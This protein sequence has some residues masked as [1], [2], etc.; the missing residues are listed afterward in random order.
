VNARKAR[1]TA[2]VLA[3]VAAVF[4]ADSATAHTEMP[5][6]AVTRVSN[7]P[8]T[9]G[10]GGTLRISDRT[11]NRGG[12]SAGR[13]TTRYFIGRSATDEKATVLRGGRTVEPLAPRASHGSP[14]EV[15][16]PDVPAGTYEL[17]ACADARNRIRESDEGNNCGSA[18]RSMRVRANEPPAVFIGG[19]S[20]PGIPA[21]VEGEASPLMPGLTVTDPDDTR[22]TGAT[23][24][25]IGAGGAGL[26][27]VNQLGITGTYNS[28]TGVLTL[29][30]TANGADYR[31]A[32]R[33]V[34]YRFFGDDP[35]GSQRFS[36]RVRDAKAAWSAPAR[37]AR[38]ITPVNDPPQ[39]AIVGTDVPFD[40]GVFDPDSQVAGASVRLLDAGSG[41]ELAFN[42]QL[43]ITGTYNSGTGVLTLTGQAS[44]SDYRAAIRSVIVTKRPGATGPRSF[45]MQVS[46]AGGAT[47]NI[48]PY[49]EQQP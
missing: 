24:A 3:I 4:G 8:A 37:V 39:L 10:V 9:I 40:I 11:T 18:G 26:Y 41:D 31:S 32:L 34:W 46:D 14:R 17:V 21:I 36:V 30:G 29:R 2:V 5:D 45:E 19:G 27:F 15:V 1:R 28:G 16:I 12:G 47:S 43:G 38:D 33:S 35:R 22:F 20:M 44:P 7:P 25:L 49:V 6:L 42:P 13:S 48:L 23:V